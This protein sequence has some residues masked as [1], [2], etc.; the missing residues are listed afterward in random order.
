MN[1]A[2]FA[3]LAAVVA[4]LGL[5]WLCG[6]ESMVPPVAAMT[7]A[8]APARVSSDA[9]AEWLPVMREGAEVTFARNTS[10]SV[11]DP[12]TPTA[13]IKTLGPLVGDDLEAVIA[14]L[15]ERAH[16]RFD[17]LQQMPVSREPGIPFA[18]LE[19]AEAL[20]ETEE[21]LAAAEALRKGQYFVTAVGKRPPGA[22]NA[23]L[24]QTT[25]KQNGKMV[26]VSIVMPFTEY[27]RFADAYSYRREM[28]FRYPASAMDYW[29]SQDAE[30]RR[31]AAARA[32]AT[33]SA[34]G[35]AADRA[36]RRQYAP[37]GTVVD[38]VTNLMS[39]VR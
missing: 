12:A 22:P 29:N 2:H 3:I 39:L 34:S 21:S 26:L 9:F 5:S 36:W 37:N 27:P 10:G 20:C 31:Q 13:E 23:G 38:P 6:N 32:A 19:Q 11:E 4:A 30:W 8:T 1:R 33:K 15:Q 35:T 14:R 28:Y 16:K 24:V 25:A 18:V 17:D 7:G